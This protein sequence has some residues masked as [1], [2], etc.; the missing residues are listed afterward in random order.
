[1][2]ITDTV[3]GITQKLPLAKIFQVA[4]GGGDKF[5][6]ITLDRNYG[7]QNLGVL[8]RI[9]EVALEDFPNSHLTL[10]EVC[11]VMLGGD[12]NGMWG[13]EFRVPENTQ[14][15]EGYR[16]QKSELKIAGGY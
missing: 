5:V 10:D 14:I 3:K 16:E 2:G 4:E 9:F 12:K 13:I 1:M 6:Q 8:T 7:G 15:P 11:A